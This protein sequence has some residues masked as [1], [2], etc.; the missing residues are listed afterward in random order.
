V[1]AAAFSSNNIFKRPRKYKN[2]RKLRKKNPHGILE[3]EVKVVSAAYD[4]VRQ[5]W[6]YTLVDY[7]GDPIGGET[8]ESQLG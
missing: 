5:K 3:Y 7:K 1:V 6:M 2:G 8:E 4:G